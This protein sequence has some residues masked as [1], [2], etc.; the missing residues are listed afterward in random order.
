MSEESNMVVGEAA[1]PTTATET[2]NTTEPTLTDIDAIEDRSKAFTKDNDGKSRESRIADA[3]NQAKLEQMKIAQ[4]ASL[5]ELGDLSLPEGKGVDFKS[6]VDAL[7]DDAKTLLGNL[8]ADYTR[9]TQELAEQRKALQ[10]QFE[11]LND[12]GV[13]EKAKALADADP[14]ELDPYDTKSFEQRIE[15]EVAKR[16]EQ[17]L[18]PIQEQQEMQVRQMKLDKFK[19]EHPDLEE[20]K[21]DVAKAL[22]SNHNLSLEDAYYI[23]KGRKNTDRLNTLE[24]E[25]RNRKIQ[26]QQAGL[27][28][29]SP[30][31]FSPNRPPSHLKSGHQIY[32]WLKRNAGK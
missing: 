24:E 31:D 25:N 32:D 10:A 21:V 4:N 26:M 20:M 18:Q 19:S 22:Q 27:K 3:V 11:S 14:V 5:E 7:P 2:A 17:L 13:Y 28:I 16:M 8:R 30:R 6:V 15:Q 9:K 12:S 29:G 1:D 23:V